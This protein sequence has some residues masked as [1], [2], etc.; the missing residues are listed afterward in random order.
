[1]QDNSY[2]VWPFQAEKKLAKTELIVR[3]RSHPIHQLMK[4][5]V[6]R[7][8]GSGWANVTAPNR[9]V[10]TTWP[11]CFFPSRSPKCRLRADP[12]SASSKGAPRR[13]G[14]RVGFRGTCQSKLNTLYIGL[15]HPHPPYHRHHT[16]TR[17]K[18][19]RPL[20]HRAE[21]YLGD[22]VFLR[23][24]FP[25]RLACRGV[26]QPAPSK[27]PSFSAAFCVAECLHV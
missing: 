4:H 3:F 20:S 25:S 18:W 5:S 2:G 27:S 17:G 10:H 21:R 22:M 16:N 1:M 6:S 12:R 8:S 14:G 11:L 9:S 13:G 19:D 24:F 15:T 23:F 26:G 7:A